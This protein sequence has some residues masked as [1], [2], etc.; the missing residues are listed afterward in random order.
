MSKRDLGASVRQRLLQQGG[1]FA[2]KSRRPGRMVM[3]VV[4][5]HPTAR[6][7]TFYL[8]RLGLAPILELENV[9]SV[10]APHNGKKRAP[11]AAL[12]K[13]GPRREGTVKWFGVFVR[14]RLGL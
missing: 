14:G 3:G 2:M 7:V 1:T 9:R 6:I 5:K 11:S 12:A 4:G 13:L 10:R 8:V